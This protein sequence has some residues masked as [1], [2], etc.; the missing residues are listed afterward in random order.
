L[1]FNRGTN[2]VHAQHQRPQVVRDN[3]TAKRPGVGIT[4]MCWDEVLEQVAQKD[5]EKDELI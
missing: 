3:I 1:F 2:A 5:Y 4:P